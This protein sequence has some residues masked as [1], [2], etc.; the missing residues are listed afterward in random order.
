MKANRM[1]TAATL[2]V[3]GMLKKDLNRLNQRTV[4]NVIAKTRPS[5]TGYTSAAMVQMMV[6]CNDTTKWASVNNSL[7]FNNP[8][9]TAGVIPSSWVKL[10]Q[11]VTTTGESRNA[12]ANR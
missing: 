10:C 12:A 8:T 4:L 6:F 9:K 1:P 7:K 11:M 3:D 2:M 5:V